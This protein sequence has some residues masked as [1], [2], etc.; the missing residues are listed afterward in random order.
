MNPVAEAEKISGWMNAVEL[1][2]LHRTAASLK[3]GAIWV[4]VGSW[5]GRSLVSVGLSLAR[6]SQLVAVDRFSGCP[7]MTDEHTQIAKRSLLEV[8]EYLRFNADDVHVQFLEMA[9]VDAAA[10]F[11]D[12]TCDVVFLDGDHDTDS[13]SSDI[14]AWLPKVKTGGILC[15]HDPTV[16]AAVVPVFGWPE[17]ED[18]IWHVQVERNG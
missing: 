15:G 13:V 4:E 3:P 1:E 14:A 6:G 11:L 12:E 8:V 5:A 7:G 16:L 2:W 9:S 18:T 10:M 17:L